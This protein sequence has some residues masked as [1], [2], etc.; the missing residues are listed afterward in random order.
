[1]QERLLDRD[2]QSNF[3][4]AAIDDAECQEPGVV[5]YTRGAVDAQRLVHARHQKQQTDARINQ[6]VRHGVEPVVSDPEMSAPLGP[7][8][9]TTQKGES[10]MIRRQWSS[11][12]LSTLSVAR[13]IGS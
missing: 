10:D 6:K 8:V 5:G 4:L 12:A 1:M 2:D 9:A 13:L 3:R 7:C 11:S